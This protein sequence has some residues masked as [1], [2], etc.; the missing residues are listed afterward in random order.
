MIW[1]EVG[2]P[3]WSQVYLLIAFRHLGTPNI[4]SGF[5]IGNV[6]PCGARDHHIYIYIYFIFGKLQT[7]TQDLMVWKK[8]RRGMS[9]PIKIAL[10]F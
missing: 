1:L 6:C 3:H 9:V 7:W 5:K 4:I 8:K 10:H 2:C